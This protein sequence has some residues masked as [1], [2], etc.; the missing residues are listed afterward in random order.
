V[1]VI[2]LA[3]LGVGCATLVAA[4]EP[5]VAIGGFG[6][7]GLAFGWAMTGLSTVVQERAPEELRGRIMALWLV[8]FLGCRPLAA[9]LLGGTADAFNVHAAFALAAV[10][11]LAVALWCRPSNITGPLPARV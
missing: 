11:C 9:P 1:S 6:V 2:G 3:G 5:A 8:G 10:L 4:A 7:T